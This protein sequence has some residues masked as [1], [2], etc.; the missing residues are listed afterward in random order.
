MKLLESVE[1]KAE[2]NANSVLRGENT[3][4]LAEIRE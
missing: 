3:P 1:L 4:T 2:K